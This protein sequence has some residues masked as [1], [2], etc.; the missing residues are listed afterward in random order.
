MVS[1]PA[2]SE[3]L[4]L[5]YSTP[6][7]DGEWETFLALLSRRT[8]SAVSVFLAADNRL[9][10]SCRAQ[11]GSGPDQR[12][13]ALAYNE[14]YVQ[15][16]PFRA[17][18]LRDPRPRIAQSEELLPNNGLINTKL[19]R[20]LLAPHGFRYATLVLLT[21]TIRRIEIITIWRT[22][23]QGP[24]DEHSIALLD[25]LFPHILQ[26]L[27]IRQAIGI[28]QQRLTAA[29]ALANANSTAIFLVTKD[30][31]VVNANASAKEL[32]SN[33]G[34]LTIS[35]GVLIPA[36]LE[37][38]RKFLAALSHASAICIACNTGP[39]Q[40]IS[41][42]RSDGGRP[43]HLL[44][45]P[46]PPAQRSYTRADAMVLVGDPDR[47]IQFPDQ[48]LRTLYGLTPAEIETANGL[49]L[50]YS[51]HEIASLRRVSE[52]TVRNQI[53]ATMGKTNTSRQS[54]LIQLLMSIPHPPRTD[55]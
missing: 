23:D 4:N 17:P 9:G 39:N 18:C 10:V 49:L 24:M 29:E 48:V 26:T 38:R 30:G 40:A 19:Y 32:T 25:L 21:L 41:V 34:P 42:P 47:P 16:D 20:D 46:L 7:Q 2:F 54:E 33:R 3:L 13:D 5:L 43:L 8:H 15:D 11:G 12:V 50:G 28:M 55:A 6:F 14:K 51:A 36:P 45:T 53:K 1:L 52:R 31:F 35:E 22:T 27:E 44:V 37:R